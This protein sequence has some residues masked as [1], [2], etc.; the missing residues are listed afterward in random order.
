MFLTVISNVFV[1]VMFLNGSISVLFN[2]FKI[3]LVFM[4]RVC[5]PEK[6]YLFDN[7]KTLRENLEG[8]GM[9]LNLHGGTMAHSLWGCTMVLYECKNHADPVFP[10][11]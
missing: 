9:V 4:R 7:S 3:I 8:K 5:G 1:S 6:Y 10:A 2:V 11:T